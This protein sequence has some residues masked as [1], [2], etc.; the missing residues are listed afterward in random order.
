[1]LGRPFEG[2]IRDQQVRAALD[3][4]IWDSKYQGQIDAPD[5]NMLLARL[6][7]VPAGETL[8]TLKSAASHTDY[9]KVMN[10]F[11][12][13]LDTLE[14]KGKGDA[15]RQFDTLIK[16]LN[17][18]DGW[19]FSKV[20]VQDV[21]QYFNTHFLKAMRGNTEFEAQLDKLRKAVKGLS[22]RVY[23]LQG[24]LRA[25]AEDFMASTLASKVAGKYAA[26]QPG[27]KG[28]SPSGQWLVDVAKTFNRLYAKTSFIMGTP[29]Y[30]VTGPLVYVRAK[31]QPYNDAG[32]DSLNMWFKN[33]V[34]TVQVSGNYVGEGADVESQGF[35]Q[36]YAKKDFRLD[37]TGSPEA[38]AKKI[39]DLSRSMS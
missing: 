31:F 39:Y 17:S 14:G 8:M 35:G 38:F 20:Q 12:D 32:V 9:K 15:N 18:A 25:T 28:F 36:V 37:T 10:A 24:S 34:I 33:G 26:L 16:T 30:E 4:A 6:A 22:D 11:D 21:V 1:M 5:Y 23:K 29:E 19:G 7:G 2:A 13:L 3:L 27:Q